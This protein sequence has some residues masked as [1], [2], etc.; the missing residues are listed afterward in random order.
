MTTV[1]SVSALAHLWWI[2]IFREPKEDSES[3]RKLLQYACVLMCIT[4]KTTTTINMQPEL[5]T[6]SEQL[7]VALRQY[8]CAFGEDVPQTFTENLR[9]LTTLHT[10]S[11]RIRIRENATNHKDE[12]VGKF[13]G[14][15]GFLGVVEGDG[16]WILSRFSVISRCEL[17]KKKTVEKWGFSLLPRPVLIRM[18]HAVMNTTRLIWIVYY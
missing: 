18:R 2:S 10:V 5:K 17:Y 11:I 16:G 12:I 6:V 13:K 7:V 15:R 8:A 1:Y 3:K 9:R 4:W 14:N